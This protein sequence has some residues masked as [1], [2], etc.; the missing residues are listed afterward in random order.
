MKFKEFVSWCN[1]RTCDGCWSMLVA[2][3]CINV[4]DKVREVPLWKREKYWKQ[5]YESRVLEEIV[6]PINQKIKEVY[7]GKQGKY[8]I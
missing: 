8:Q 5:E 7:G 6:N 1:D 3:T 2:L 4:I